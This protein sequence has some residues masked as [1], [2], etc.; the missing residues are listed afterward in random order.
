MNI[1]KTLRKLQREED[2]RMNYRKI[3]QEKLGRIQFLITE[4]GI[5]E[6]Q[7]ESVEADLH[8]IIWKLKNPQE[9]ST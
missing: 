1:K 9:K 6:D 4:S 7:L 2:R 8:R 3:I 5:T